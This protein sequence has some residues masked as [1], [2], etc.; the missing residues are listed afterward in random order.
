MS[1]YLSIKNKLSE[2]SQ[3]ILEDKCNPTHLKTFEVFT[4]HFIKDIH[5]FEE[6]S[7]SCNQGNILNLI[8]TTDILKYWPEYENIYNDKLSRRQQMCEWNEYMKL[9]Y[10]NAFCC[11]KDCH[12]ELR[13]VCPYL[14]G[15]YALADITLAQI[16]DG[17]P[18]YVHL[19]SRDKYVELKSVGHPWLAEWRDDR[20]PQDS[21]TGWGIKY[22]IMYGLLMYAIVDYTC[23]LSISMYTPNGS[24]IF[25]S[26]K[27]DCV[28][29]LRH[30]VGE[31]LHI[32]RDEAIAVHDIDYDRYIESRYRVLGTPLKKVQKEVFF[33]KIMAKEFLDKGEYAARCSKGKQVQIQRLNDASLFKLQRA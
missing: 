26:H 28:E 9:W 5:Y 15:V 31:V 16:N 22:G 13:L 33:P 32:D 3:I 1:G 24:E 12:M 29:D 23:L 10:T 11:L 18:G 6:N 17:L 7:S 20:I 21:S 25:E 30:P 19:I 27:F 2:A 4:E 14:A 8:S